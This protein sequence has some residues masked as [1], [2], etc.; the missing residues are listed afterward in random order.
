MTNQ[1]Q[2]TKETN[3]NND[4]NRKETTMKE[5]IREAIREAINK[6][7]RIRIPSVKENYNT[8][9]KY[10]KVNKKT[11]V[12]VS[13]AVAAGIVTGTLLDLL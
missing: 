8:T 7:I 9:K 5:T 3:T 12:T 10:I 2:Q 1:Q 6:D 11:I 4:T 13:V